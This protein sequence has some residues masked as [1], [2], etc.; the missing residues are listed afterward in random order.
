MF[1]ISRAALWF[2]DSDC[3]YF[4]HTIYLEPDMKRAFALSLLLMLPPLGA[5]A[6]P[7]DGCGGNS[8]TSD[9]TRASGFFMDR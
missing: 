1:L 2:P 7:A 9:R 8:L 5:L 4:G 6:S 3:L